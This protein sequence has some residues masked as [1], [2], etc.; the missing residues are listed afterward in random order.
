MQHTPTL[1]NIIFIST[2]LI[3]AQ[4]EIPRVENIIQVNQLE[5]TIVYYDRA[6]GQKDMYYH[7]L[8]EINN[9]KVIRAFHFPLDPN[10]YNTLEF[11]NDILDHKTLRPIY[12]KYPYGEI[13]YDYGK[14]DTI[15]LKFSSKQ[16]LI[17]KEIKA[18]NHTYVTK[19][20][21]VTVLLACLPLK[22]GLKARFSSLDLMFPYFSD[23]YEIKIVDYLLHVTN[24]DTISNNGK[25]YKTF[26]VEFYPENKADKGVY[27]KVW[28]TQKSPHVSIQSIY[29]SSDDKDDDNTD[30]I[31]RIRKLLRFNE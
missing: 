28:L 8:D 9:S 3:C 22:V 14:E 30:R 23:N 18:T 25:E 17:Q 21:A 19:G 29:A 11:D 7:A 27:F 31:S 15:A 13:H 1:L 5:N 26:V 12:K 24:T 2:S 16:G 6:D 10:I 20:P 4:E